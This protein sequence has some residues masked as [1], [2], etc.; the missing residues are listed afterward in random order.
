M[1][2]IRRRLGAIDIDVKCKDAWTPAMI[3]GRC[4]ADWQREKKTVEF[5]FHTRAFGRGM[6]ASSTKLS[7]GEHELKESE[8]PLPQH[9]DEKGEACGSRRQGQA[10]AGTGTRDKGGEAIVV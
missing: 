8:G 7:R 10:E 9:N 4:V 2:G 3:V 6:I 1:D 5:P